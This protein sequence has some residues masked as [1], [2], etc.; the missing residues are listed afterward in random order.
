MYNK[1]KKREKM[2]KKLILPVVFIL[3]TGCAEL[4]QLAEQYDQSRPLTNREV[5]NGLKEALIIGAEKAADRLSDVDG[6]YLDNA[7]KITLPPEARTITENLSLIPGGDKLIEEVVLRINRAAE[8]AAREAAPIFG[9]AVREMSIQDGFAILRGDKDAATQYLKSKTHTDLFNLYKP[10]IESSIDKPIV[11]DIS[12]RDSWDTLTGHWNKIAASPIG[13]ASNLET[14][15]IEL[16]RYLTEK[17]LAGLFH[18]LAQEEEK[19][20]TNPA[21]R[22]TELL[23]RVFGQG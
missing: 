18:K 20:R 12:T 10:K 13:R 16:A 19:I 2:T 5:I 11:G 3:V 1:K 17:A 15:D 22:V 8:N 4:T 7:V 23:K 14:V 21:A 6:Y 9:R